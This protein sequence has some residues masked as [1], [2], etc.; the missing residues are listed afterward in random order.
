VLTTSHR[1]AARQ[2][3]RYRL[4]L[5]ESVVDIAGT[6]DRLTTFYYPDDLEAFGAIPILESMSV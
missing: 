6:L 2:F 4:Q 3:S 5:A 1:K